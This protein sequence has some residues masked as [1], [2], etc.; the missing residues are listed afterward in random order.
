MTVGLSAVGALYVAAWS[1]AIAAEPATSNAAYKWLQRFA[2]PSNHEMNADSNA[3]A[4]ISGKAK[5]LV[6]L[7]AACTK[8]SKHAAAAL[9]LPAAPD[10]GVQIAW[11]RM[12]N[13]TATWAMDC[14]TM[15]NTSTTASLTAF[16]HASDS[17]N[18][19]VKNWNIYS[20]AIKGH[21]PIPKMAVPATTSTTTAPPTTT[22]TTDPTP[23][24]DRQGTE[25]LLD[26]VAATYQGGALGWRANSSNTDSEATTGDGFCE[27]SLV[28]D[29]GEPHSKIDN[30]TIRCGLPLN[31]SSVTKRM[32][33]EEAV[34]LNAVL[35]Q[36][37]GPSSVSWLQKEAVQ[38]ANGP[39]VS[40]QQY[41]GSVDVYVTFGYAQ[42]STVIT[43]TY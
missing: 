14:V 35:Q 32:A 29:E 7:R 27:F 33:S 28:N 40:T 3:I 13:A 21:R 1:P 16:N 31:P 23:Y 26:Q 20:A 36:Y 19:S 5:N 10:A 6:D 17:L 24:F 8:L 25:V 4:A 15:V 41:F 38:A 39:G 12:V 11:L 18:S 2:E 43:T 37:A 42:T 30:I 9:H 22:T 34:Y